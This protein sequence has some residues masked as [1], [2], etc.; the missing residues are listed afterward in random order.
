MT[1]C[2]LYS[3]LKDWMILFAVYDI[4]TGDIVRTLGGHRSVVRDCCWHPDENEIITV[5]VSS[6]TSYLWHHFNF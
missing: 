2:L 4:L 5:S 1:A 3:R 6:T